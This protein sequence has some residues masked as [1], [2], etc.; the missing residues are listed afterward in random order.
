MPISRKAGAES[1]NIPQ[2][3]TGPGGEGLSRLTLGTVLVCLCLVV[4][5]SPFA[6]GFADSARAAPGETAMTLY[7]AEQSHLVTVQS[8][9][10]DYYD[11]YG[12]CINI[13]V[14]SNTTGTLNLTLEPGRI[15][16][17]NNISVQNMVITVVIVFTL[18]PNEYWN[19]TVNATCINLD[20][21]APGPDDHYLLGQMATGDIL[22]IAQYLSTREQNFT[23]AELMWIASDNVPVDQSDPVLW[24][25]YQEAL[26]TTGTGTPGSTWL[27][28]IVVVVIVAA[29]GLVAA[30][31]VVGRAKK[32]RLSPSQP[33]QTPGAC[34]RCGA[35]LSQDWMVC[36]NCGLNLKK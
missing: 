8:T 36:P 32:R 6:S 16:V 24:N 21:D 19:R 27:I 7:Q 15:L 3:E 2:T 11:F 13:S 12:E 17:C 18:H 5:A 35:Q 1:I 33:L 14:K 4:A 23:T 9:G 29:A 22:K 26:G 25:M 20:R 31:V 28:V 30:F 34:P 10:G